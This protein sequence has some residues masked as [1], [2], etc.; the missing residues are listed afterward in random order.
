LTDAGIFQDTSTIIRDAL[1]QSHAK[2]SSKTGIA[3]T[4]FEIALNQL[5]K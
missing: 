4:A 3:K 2:N 5:V 1:V